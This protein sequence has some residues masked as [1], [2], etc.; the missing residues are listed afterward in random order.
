MRV[1]VE[2]VQQFSTKIRDDILGNN[3][4]RFYHL[5]NNTTPP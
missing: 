2:Y 3:C 1:V 5:E 4:A